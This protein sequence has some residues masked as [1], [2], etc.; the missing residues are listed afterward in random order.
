MKT[1]NGNS[2]D[3]EAEQLC[4]IKKKKRVF[5][6]FFYTPWVTSQSIV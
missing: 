3:D 2:R 4:W 1:A 5:E 6:A